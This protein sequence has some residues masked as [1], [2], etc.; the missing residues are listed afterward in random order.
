MADSEVGVP[1]IGTTK[2]FTD[3]IGGRHHEVVKIEVGEE[4]SGVFVSETDPMPIADAAAQTTLESVLAAFAGLV[5]TGDLSTLATSAKQD[6]AHADLAALLTELSALATSAKQDV[7]HT[8]LAAILAK[9]TAD[10]ATQTTLAAVLAALPALVHATDLATLATT[11]KQDVTHADLA[12]LLAELDQKVEPSDLASLATQT[13]LAAV[14]TTLAAVLAKLSADPATQTTL[15]AVLAALAGTLTTAPT[16][17]GD[18]ATTLTD[19]RKT[20]ATP[21]TAVA[22]RASLACKWVRVTALKTNTSLIYVG[23]SGVIAA[24]GTETGTPLAAGDTDTFPVD[25]AN[26]LFIDARVAT[27]GASGTVGS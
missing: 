10:P 8:D 1:N 23:G 4:G 16:T 19:F 26:K 2:V 15:A 9:L 22:V 14:Q 18:V 21:G 25:N 20:V 27:E 11:A 6:I 24:S 7:A 3:L 13:T 12:A 17:A 5:H